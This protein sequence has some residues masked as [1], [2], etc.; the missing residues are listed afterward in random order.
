MRCRRSHFPSSP[1]MRGLPHNG[2]A[3]ETFR[4]SLRTSLLIGGGPAFRPR[5]LPTQSSRKRW[6]CEAITVAGRTMTRTCCHPVQRRDSQDQNRAISRSNA[7]SLGSLVDRQL[8]SQR[9]DFQL[10]R[11]VRSKKRRESHPQRRE[12]GPHRLRPH[13]ICIRTNGLKLRASALYVN[14]SGSAIV[15]E[16]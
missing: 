3:P 14:R 5:I 10:Q 6:R 2:F 4:M 1:M 13:Q 9:H 16:S 11:E 15:P 7:W 8:M 12:N